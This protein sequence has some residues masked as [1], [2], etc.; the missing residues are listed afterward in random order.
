MAIG[1]PLGV[2]LLRV[3][4]TL[5]D[6]RTGRATKLPYLV[7]MHLSGFSGSLPIL[8][9]LAWKPQRET[10]SNMVL[11]MRADRIQSTSSC[12]PC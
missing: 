10:L 5:R 8:S 3:P 9:C 11:L 4:N 1:L 6:M 2:M 7:R 12:S